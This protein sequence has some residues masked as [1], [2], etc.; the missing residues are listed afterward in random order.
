MECF[1]RGPFLQPPG[2]QSGNFGDSSRIVDSFLVGS[3]GRDSNG[4]DANAG[5]AFPVLPY[6]A[7]VS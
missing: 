6:S 2:L 5:V 1:L 7:R 4:F 3:G